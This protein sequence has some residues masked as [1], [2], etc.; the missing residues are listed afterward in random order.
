MDIE[1]DLD[2]E[3]ITIKWEDLQIG[4]VFTDGSKVMEIRDWEYRP[5]YVL[6][7]NESEIIVS[8]EHLFN[9]QFYKD[10]VKIKTEAKYG[11]KLISPWSNASDIFKAFNEG[12]DIIM[13]PLSKKV[14]DIKPFLN[15]EPQRC[16]CITTDTGH[17]QIGDFN[18]H[19]TTL[20]KYMSMHDIENKP[21]LCIIEDTSEL[22]IDVPISL[23]TNN[24]SKIKDLFKATLR[25]NPSHIVIGETRTD[26]IVD[27]LNAALTINVAST[28]HAN[29]FN[30]A[31]Q[32]IVFMAIDRRIKSEEILNLIN[33]AIDCFIFMEK[34]KVKE[35]WVHKDKICKDVYEAYE[36]II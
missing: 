33:A 1:N 31:I 28:I 11:D 12:I 3:K 9:C 18:N 19:N 24:H 20:L 17:Y 5:C 32:R 10:G 4:D 22:N 30:R 27:I 21:N 35:I 34:R 26:E 2:Y 13:L 16:R 25:E 23:L 7:T 29:S 8:D 15:G 14:N 6:K 36:K